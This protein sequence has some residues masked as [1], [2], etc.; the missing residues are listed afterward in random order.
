MPLFTYVAAYRG[1]VHLEQAREKSSNYR[2]WATSIMGQ[3]PEGALPGLSKSLRDDLLDKVLRAKW[4]ALPN[5]TGA[6][7]T[8]FDLAGA[9]FVLFAIQTEA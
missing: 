1:A 9:E 4:E 8:A 2:G 6:W 3:M 5:R 7:R